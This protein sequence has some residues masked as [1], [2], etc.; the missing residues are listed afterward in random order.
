MTRPELRSEDGWILVTAMTLMTV[1]LMVGLASFA[2][3]DGNQKRTREQRERETSLN[4]AEGVLY[5][6]G[7]A[8]AQQWPGNATQGAAMPTVCDQ[9]FAAPAAGTPRKC[10]D[11]TGIAGSTGSNFTNVDASAEVTYATRIRDNAGP[12]AGAF[13]FGSVDAAQ[14]GTNAK[15]GLAY[16]CPGP[17]K[18]D[19]NGDR[20]LWVQTRS[21]V[22]GKP[23]NVVALLKRELFAEAFARNGVV[24]GSF[25]TSNNGN[26]TIIDATG[27]QVVTRCTGTSASCTKY[28]GANP[29]DNKEQVTPE[30]IVQNAGYPK[31]MTAS[32]LARFKTAAQTADPPTYYTS[33]PPTYTGTVVYIDV[34]ATTSCSDT[35]GATYNSPTDY[36]IVI[37]PRGTLTN[38]QGTYYAI[39]YVG[40]EQNSSGTVL[41]IGAN[42]QIFGGVSVDGPGHLIVG[43]AS[44]PR[45]T[46]V[47]KDAA[48]NSLATFGTAGLVQN[49]WRELPPN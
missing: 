13:V 44:G 11:P 35:N 9:T 38:L 42:A 2:F 22:R 41:E 29:S 46:I 10:P 23:R 30:P 4:V 37:M 26:K 34:P 12:L 32:Q 27:S 31:G 33:C 5:N 20:Q 48:F 47:Y 28:E 18:W 39:L 3:V 36:G 24:A 40:N 19:A 25:E 8:L 7:F 1:M 14:T 17:C 21:E 16:T 49:T 6:Q 45:A 15:T 43:Q